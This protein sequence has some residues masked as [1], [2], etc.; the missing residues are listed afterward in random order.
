MISKTLASLL[1]VGVEGA[2]VAEATARREE[3]EKEDLRGIVR[4]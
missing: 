2:V 4:I 1:F 3:E